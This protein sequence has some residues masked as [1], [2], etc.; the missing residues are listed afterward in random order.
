MLADDGTAGRE[1]RS[2][3]TVLLLPGGEILKIFG[4][5]VQ[6]WSVF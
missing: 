2:V 4:P 3:D 5:A 1:S 6:I